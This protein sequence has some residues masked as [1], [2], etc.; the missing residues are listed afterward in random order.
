MIWS[1]LFLIGTVVMAVLAGLSWAVYGVYDILWLAWV[2]RE[3]ER[4]AD[5]WERHMYG[6]DEFDPCSSTCEGNR[7]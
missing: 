1:Q 4:H 6:C 5:R 2:D 7:W 3:A